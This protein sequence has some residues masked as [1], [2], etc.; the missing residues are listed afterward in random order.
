MAKSLIDE[1]M[2]EIEGTQKKLRGIR[3]KVLSAAFAKK[4]DPLEIDKVCA[5]ICECL[6]TL[7]D[8]LEFLDPNKETEG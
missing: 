7:E 5:D 2:D 6:I 4:H 8:T 3:G 1:I